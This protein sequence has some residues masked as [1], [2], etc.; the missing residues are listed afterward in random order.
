MFSTLSIR[1]CSFRSIIETERR[2]NLENKISSTPIF[3]GKV[4]RVTQDEV[5]V[6]NGTTS[7]RECV[8]ANG[9]VAILAFID[10]KI[11]FVKQYR[12]VVGEETIEIPAGKIE[13]GEDLSICAQREL[14]EE[15]G[16]A[17]ESIEKVLSFYPTPGFCGEELHIFL[18]HKLSKLEHPKAM[19]EDECI[20]CILMSAEEAYQAVKQGLIKD[21]KTILAIQMALLE[22]WKGD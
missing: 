19:D 1:H 13:V 3:N 10:E 14:E 22:N 9:G 6:S 4:I 18:A 2:D 17:A 16:Y 12:Y 11:L 5:S 8:Y 7:T 20:E 21:S 15:T